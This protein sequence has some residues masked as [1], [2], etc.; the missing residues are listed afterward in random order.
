MPGS[1][2]ECPAPG[3]MCSVISGQTFFNAYAVV[4]YKHTT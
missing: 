3:T 2:D 1:R 4:G